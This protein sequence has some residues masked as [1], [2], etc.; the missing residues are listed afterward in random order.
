MQRSG[1]SR[2]PVR[3]SRNLQHDDPAEGVPMDNK[4]IASKL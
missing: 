1:Q 2:Q 3:N 4:E